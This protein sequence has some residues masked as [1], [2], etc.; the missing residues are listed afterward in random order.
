MTEL[1]GSKG[2][3]KQ[4][5]PVSGPEGNLQTNC[6]I[7]QTRSADSKSLRWAGDTHS[8]TPRGARLPQ[9]TPSLSPKPRTD[10][11][12]SREARTKGV[13]T[14]Y[15]SQHLLTPRSLGEA[16]STTAL[17]PMTQRL[18]NKSEQSHFI[19]IL[20]LFISQVRGAHC[21]RYVTHTG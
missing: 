19:S 1:W 4:N 13:G 11:T 3:L 8:L 10:G 2:N 21:R 12:W 9:A 7:L 15:L 16:A 5:S 20:K 17:M 6:P 18:K 14:P